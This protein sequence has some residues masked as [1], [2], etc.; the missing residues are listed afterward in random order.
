M[1]PIVLEIRELDNLV[2]HDMPESCSSL[3]F[4]GIF[5]NDKYDQFW[6]LVE[7]AVKQTQIECFRRR[8]IPPPQYS[9]ESIR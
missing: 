6:G 2:S 3:V 7:H 9:F 1:G 4:N 8:G 5:G